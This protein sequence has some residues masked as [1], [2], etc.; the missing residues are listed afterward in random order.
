MQS[1]EANVNCTGG[2]LLAHWALRADFRRLQPDQLGAR[3]AVKYF[4]NFNF[5]VLAPNGENG[6]QGNKICFSTVTKKKKK[7]ARSAIKHKQKRVFFFSLY[8][9]SAG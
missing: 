6:K 7:I 1:R 4:M 5:T 2:V 8:Q 3:V 9:C